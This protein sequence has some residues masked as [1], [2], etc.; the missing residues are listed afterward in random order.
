MAGG[1]VRGPSTVFVQPVS[2]SVSLSSA[3][4]MLR[5]SSSTQLPAVQLLVST[6]P[7]MVS[8][9]ECYIHS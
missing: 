5:A 6:A 3:S 9:C 4:P 2:S 7:A 1:A 8:Q